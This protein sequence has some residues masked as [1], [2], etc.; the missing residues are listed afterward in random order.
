MH[1]KTLRKKKTNIQIMNTSVKSE[2]RKN[3][4]AN[5]K[6]YN[7]IRRFA[8]SESDCINILSHQLNKNEREERKNNLS[9][10]CSFRHEIYPDWRTP[11]RVIWNDCF[12]PL[13]RHVAPTVWMPKIP[14]SQSLLTKVGPTKS[15]SGRALPDV[16]SATWLLVDFHLIWPVF[17]HRI[18]TR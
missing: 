6:N 3:K 8:K 18:L 13:G 16:Q 12:W 14:P 1:I 2:A 9:F 11:R 4:L 15:K 17:V 5:S 7:P 10:S